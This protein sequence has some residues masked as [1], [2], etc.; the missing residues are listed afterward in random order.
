MSRDHTIVDEEPDFEIPAPVPVQGKVVVTVDAP[1][2]WQ[3][4]IGHMR[5]FIMGPGPNAWFPVSL[6]TSKGSPGT[7]KERRIAHAAV[8]ILMEKHREDR[9][10]GPSV[11]RRVLEDLGWKPDPLTRYPKDK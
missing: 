3:V 4:V 11:I 1:P 10:I 7:P 2:H 8:S 6:P 9:E 5:L